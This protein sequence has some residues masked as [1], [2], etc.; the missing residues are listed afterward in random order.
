MSPEA[1]G[2]ETWVLL[3]KV[4]VNRFVASD[5]SI[6][7]NVNI[8]VARH[9][10]KTATIMRNM[11]VKSWER[12][13]IARNVFIIHN[14]P[15][16]SWQRR[17]HAVWLLAIVNILRLN[18]LLLVCGWP[19]SGLYRIM[20]KTKNKTNSVAFSPQA[21]YTDWTTATCSRNLVPTFVDRG[22][23]RNQRGG[24]TTVVNLSFL[25]RGC[26]LSFK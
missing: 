16:C 24:S 19:T 12:W 25:D 23:S 17:T 3:M 20:N 21:N 9:V 5:I 8:V 7:R 14:C 26:Y 2:E 6:A 4:C 22:V 18:L 10:D 11:V 13:W 15:G 1:Q